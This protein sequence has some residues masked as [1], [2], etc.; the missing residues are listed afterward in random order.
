M[1]VLRLI[2]EMKLLPSNDRLEYPM[3]Y[4]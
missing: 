1:D 3:Q 2:N 4:P